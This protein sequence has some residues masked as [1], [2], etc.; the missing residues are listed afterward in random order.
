MKP[1]ENVTDKGASGTEPIRLEVIE[2][3]KSKS[4]KR[5][6]KKEATNSEKPEV[7]IDKK[8]ER[9]QLNSLDHYRKV[10]FYFVLDGNKTPSTLIQH[11]EDKRLSELKKIEG[12]YGAELDQI[13]DKVKKLRS[14]LD[15]MRNELKEY[16]GSKSK[17]NDDLEAIGKELATCRGGLIQLY[18]DFQKEKNAFV[19][20]RTENRIKQLGD[21]IKLLVNNSNIV[22]EELQA[23]Y[24]DYLKS[25]KDSLDEYVEYLK[26]ESNR[27]TL[28]LAEINKRIQ[29][30]NE[31]YI[32]ENTIRAL[33]V[34]C[35]AAVGAAGWFFSIFAVEKN[36][37]SADQSS[38]LLGLIFNF[39][40]ALFQQPL[41]IEVNVGILL[42]TIL[43]VVCV[44]ALVT[45]IFWFSS[46]LLFG[47]RENQEKTMSILDSQGNTINMPLVEN[48]SQDVTPWKIWL[49]NLPYILVGILVFIFLVFFSSYSNYNSSAGGQTEINKLT[50]ALSAQIIG[51]ALSLMAGGICFLYVSFIVEARLLKNQEL[52]PK[53]YWELNIVLGSFFVLILAVPLLSLLKGADYL[54]NLSLVLFF[55]TVLASGLLIGYYFKFSALITTRESEESNCAYIKKLILQFS[56]NHLGYGLGVDKRLLTRIETLNTQMTEPIAYENIEVKMIADRKVNEKNS[57]KLIDFKN[58]LINARETV[59][60][61]VNVARA[62]VNNWLNRVSKS[63]SP[64]GD[65]NIKPE[66]S[67]IT[68]FKLNN[69]DSWDDFLKDDGFEDYVAREYFI[70][71]YYEIRDTQARIKEKTSEKSNLQ[72]EIELIRLREA[73]FIIKANKTIEEYESQIAEQG[74]KKLKIQKTIDKKISKINSKYQRIFLELREGVELGKWFID[75]R[76]ILD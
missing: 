10:G 24:E 41:G 66:E 42:L 48:R 34:V 33:G 26:S 44:L 9:V 25:N 7:S 40:E 69:S 59:K 60:K 65:A 32:N 58:T 16:V 38:F 39:G 43:G 49:K 68:D 5:R 20:K 55:L 73:P 19:E 52:S 56:Q 22:S 70:D 13:E 72:K 75:N 51:A 15:Q 45:S 6:K 27:S 61:Q 29:R 67:E 36:L 71:K 53:H 35:L 63:D 28:R 4:K 1:E 11:Y 47:R 76:S 8:E 37:D 74:S 31:L 64:S 14:D 30:F 17:L 23:K 54:S 62:K 21:E 2:E 18:R 12:H 46:R 50:I 57:Q 3:K